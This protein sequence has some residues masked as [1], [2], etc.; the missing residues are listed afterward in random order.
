MLSLFTDFESFT[1]FKPAAM[2]EKSVNAMLDQEGPSSLAT[3]AQVPGRSA[4]SSARPRRS[5]TPSSTAPPRR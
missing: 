4:S 5:E 3:S 1:T 2:H